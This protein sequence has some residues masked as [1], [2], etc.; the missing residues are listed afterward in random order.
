MENE[1]KDLAFKIGGHNPAKQNLRY[2]IICSTNEKFSDDL[3]S[4]EENMNSFN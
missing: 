1:L 2:N 3:H 4:M